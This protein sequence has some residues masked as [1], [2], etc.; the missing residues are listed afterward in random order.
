MTHEMHII[1]VEIMRAAADIAS[2]K[3]LDAELAV[4][5][6]GDYINAPDEDIEAALLSL[7]CP[8]NQF[9]S[10]EAKCQTINGLHAR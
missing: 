2:A 3:G 4:E 7:R 1:R 9:T 5:G 6:V 8:S 10:K